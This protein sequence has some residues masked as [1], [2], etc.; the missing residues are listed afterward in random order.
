MSLYRNILG[1]AW[2][3]TWRYKYLWFFGLFAALLG[4][5]GEYE[6]LVRGLN[7]ETG[8]AI[9][10]AWQSLSQTGIFSSQALDNI[11]E[12][13]NN[14]PFSFVMLVGICLAILVLAGFLVWLTVVSQAS[15]VNN[16][17][18]Y[19]AG[20][21]GDFKS[22]LRMGINS[23]WPVFGLNIINKVIILFAFV[24][25]GLPIILTAAKSA[26][27]SANILY[28]FAFI[29]FMAA[30][31]SL[32]FVIKYSIAYV[33]VK[34]QKFLEAVRSG[35]R[36]F[37]Q[38]WL[39]SLEMAFV[40]FVINFLAGLALIAA[41]LILA[42]PFLFSAVLLYKLVFS[43]GFWFIA[44]LAFILFITL[45]IV[46]GAILSTFQI[47]SW[48]ALFLELINKGGMSKIVRIVEGWKTK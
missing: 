19:L 34:E 14:D 39:V 35:W 26:S 47:S 43:L 44:I 7:G 37:V 31:L 46:A 6:L 21:K 28:V 3:I 30:A 29:I 9:F 32:T 11:G 1:R 2:K 13:L 10:P 18:S 33:V 12:L 36:L 5:G 15:L 24:L 23:F 8:E 25:I 41:V 42:V 16:A 40:L 17:A 4:N 38:N 48:T 20:K 27:A 22:G 45:I